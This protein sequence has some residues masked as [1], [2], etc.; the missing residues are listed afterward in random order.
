MLAYHDDRYAQWVDCSLEIGQEL[1]K[2][3][4]PPKPKKPK[5]LKPEPDGGTA[6]LPEEPWKDDETLTG[7]GVLMP[8]N[9]SHSDELQWRGVSKLAGQFKPLPAGVVNAETYPDFKP[10]IDLNLLTKD[11]QDKRVI[12]AVNMRVK[13]PALC[14]ICIGAEGDG[15]IA[16]MLVAG[17]VVSHGQFIRLARGIYTVTVLVEPP[18]RLYSWQWEGRFLATRFTRI[19]PSDFNALHAW[20]VSV[21]ETMRKAAQTPDVEALKTVKLDP[22]SVRGKIGYFQ[23]G[24]ATDGRWWLIGPDGK[25]FYYRAVCAVN[26]GGMGG[27]RMCK[28]GLPDSLRDAW[29][30]RLTGMRFNGMGSWT[31]SEFFDSGVAFTEIIETYFVSPALRSSFPDVFDPLWETNLDEKCRAICAPLKENRHLLGYFLDNERGFME[32]FWRGQEIEVHSPT[33]LRAKVDAERKV[34]DPAVPDFNPHGLGLLQYL[35]SHDQ[36]R[37]GPAKAWEFV[38]QRHGDVQSIGKA[39]GVQFAGRDSVRELTM[40]EESLISDGYRKD[41]TDFLRL[42]IERYFSVTVNAIRR[43]DPNHLIIGCRWSGAPGPVSVE[44]EKNWVDVV[45]QNTYQAEMMEILGA[46]SDV[47]NKP[48]IV[49]ECSAVVDSFTFVRNPIE[50]PGGYRG[51]RMRQ[52]LRTRDGYRRLPLHPGIVGYTLYKWNGSVPPREV[53]EP[54][55]RGNLEAAARAVDWNNPGDNNAPLHGQIFVTLSGAKVNEDKL[56]S[57][58]P[59]V[60][61][62]VR[63]SRGNMSIGLVCDK[64]VWQPHVHGNGIRGD[65]TVSTWDGNRAGLEVK[66]RITPGLFVMQ[67]AEGTLSLSL[68]R[69]GDRLEGTFAGNFRGIPVK[70]NA[71]G[72]LHRPVASTRL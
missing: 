47:E 33:Y 66:Y 17:Q 67:Q 42:W 21:W 69:R 54:V 32:S 51:W 61:P 58:D 14:R 22:A 20:E 28:P 11:T 63:R 30:K 18:A 71:Y 57:P 64:G 3:G 41:E 7:F 13:K 29:L 53:I 26:Q 35:L 65:L 39:W 2:Y 31:T 49:G 4:L 16:R 48:L 19:E 15:T 36:S 59:A 70:G 45:S 9:R 27:R 1:D 46:T 62:S 68:E 72:Y 25:P 12:F 55:C 8:A 40:R 52:A 44:I 60:P 23:V 38:L 10:G 43:H 5:V 6:G 34:V 37:P 50:P 56:P 24:R